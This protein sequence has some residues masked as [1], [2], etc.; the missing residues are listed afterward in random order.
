MIRF[1]TATALVLACL[2]ACPLLCS[3]DA[4]AAPRAST[5]G[6]GVHVI[7]TPLAM[8]GLDRRRTVRI[9]LPPGYDASRKRY[10]VLY[11]HDGQ[12]LFDDATSFVGEWGV[13]EA[14]DALAASE[15]IELIVVGI[16]H[17]E[18]RR[19]AE[20]TPWPN[21][22]HSAVAEGDAYLDFVVHTVKPW[23]DA[24][25]RTRRG[26]EHTGMMGSSLGGLMSDYAMRRHPQVFGRIGILSPSYWY[27]DRV[28]EHALAHP[29][30]R[31]TRVWLAAG[32]QE[33]AQMSADLP[34]MAALLR[35]QSGGRIRLAWGLRPGAKHNEAA[36]REE[37]PRAARFL[38]GP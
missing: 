24:R 30:R 35:Q 27:S 29:P 9:Y 36:W 22:K 34:R 7:P 26:R 38:F 23:V 5:A 19:I 33:D 11:M 13:D 6:P 20:L 17:G 18:E 8:P 31:G 15:G 28:W 37:F 3:A 1:V 21:P 12:N 2:L 10:P 14:L 32:D 16:D 4:A 25:Y